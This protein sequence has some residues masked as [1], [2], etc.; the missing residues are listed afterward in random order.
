EMIGKTG[1]H[2]CI[3]LTNWDAIRLAQMVQ[4][5]TPV[6]FPS[7]A[8]TARAVERP[9]TARRPAPAPAPQPVRAAK[10]ADGRERIL[11]HRPGF[12]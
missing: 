7:T 1:S 10:P 9:R 3:R 12:D 11:P 2:G 4:V 8:D 6:S 5:G